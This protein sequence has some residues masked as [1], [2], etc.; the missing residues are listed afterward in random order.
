MHS[1]TTLIGGVGTD[2]EIIVC[3]NGNKLAKITLAT[4]I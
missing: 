4:S 2:P 1:K 3:E